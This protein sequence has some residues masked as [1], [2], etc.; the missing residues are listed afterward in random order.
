MELA[1]LQEALPHITAADATLVAISPQRVEHLRQMVKKHHLTFDVLMD[2]GNKVAHQFGLVYTL[3]DYLR[4]LYLKFGIDLERFNGDDSWT[5]PIPA[6]FIIDQDSVI[7]SVE[8]DQDYTTRPE[9]SD[10][11]EKL[12]GL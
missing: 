2:K 5:L 6:Q 11:V 8:A 1:A 12:R 4:E 7:R 9:P 10:T 3:P